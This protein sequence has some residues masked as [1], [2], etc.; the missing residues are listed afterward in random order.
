MPDHTRPSLELPGLTR[1]LVRN[2]LLVLVALD[3]LVLAGFS[4]RVGTTTTRTTSAP[5]TNPAAAATG[6]APV[7]VAPVPVDA[8]V[9]LGTAGVPVSDATKTPTTTPT[10]PPSKP[11]S[12]KPTAAEPDQTAT[13]LP[14]G[15]TSAA[16]CPVHI[17][18]NQTDG[19]LQSLVSFAPAFGP[20][21]A[22]AFAAASAYQPA[23]QLIGPVLA[24]Y[25]ALAPQIEPLLDP[26]L[27]A[28]GQLLDRGFSI[29]G[30]LYSPYRTSVL[31]AETTLAA[32]LAPYSQQLSSSPLGGCV[33]ELQNALLHDASAARSS[34]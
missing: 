34:S 10:T 11:R 28:W 27:S 14:E 4:V 21:S 2:V 17:A 3:L 18:D 16:E 7:P 13:P 32:A 29:L 19:G 5:V 9:P 33:I 23:L 24:K 30:P 6:V 31:E 20:F 12:P 25:P 1:S 8:G 22:E 26:L 15:S